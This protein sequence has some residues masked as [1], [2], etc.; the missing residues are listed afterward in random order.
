MNQARL[1]TFLLLLVPLGLTAG[2]CGPTGGGEKSA[3]EKPGVERTDFGR[4]RDGVPVDL[5]IMRNAGG[6]T[7]KVMTYGATLT[8]LVVPDS[9]GHMASVVLGFD[10][11]E[12]YLGNVPYFG[13]TI[14]RV[15]NRIA[16]GTFELDGQTYKLA[17]NNG[18]NH[19]HG[20]L[21]GFDKVVWHAEPN[22]GSADP[23]VTFSYRSPDGEEG[24][25][26]NLS[27]S[28]TYTLTK[29][30]EIRLDYRAT[31]DKPTP[32]NLTNHSYFNLAGEGSGTILDHYLMIAADQF[33]PVDDTLIPTGEIA[34]VAGTPMDFTSP[35]RIGAR[36]DQ[37][38]GASPGGYDHNYVLRPH[39]GLVLA[40]R[41]SDPGSGRAMEVLTTEPAVQFYSGNFLD[42]TIRGRSGV[43][44]L[45]HAALCLETQHYP[46]S[47]HHP[48]FPSTILRPG[49][50]LVS[51]TVYRFTTSPGA[52]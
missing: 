32:V 38:P 40:A 41:L 43:A 14:G 29:Q 36:I 42:G 37:V 5:Y 49:T 8:D 47:V 13:A 20:G 45:K 15:G 9:Q 24:Y 30:D 2:A 26:G 19:L 21:K 44:Y 4:T 10:S 11:L 28:V 50:E 23:S 39:D 33:T 51:Q 12:P 35:E 27:V 34:A 22:A 1:S 46:D 16:G 6:M 25:P 31:T 7:I 48:N 3:V 18:P 17:L 52:R